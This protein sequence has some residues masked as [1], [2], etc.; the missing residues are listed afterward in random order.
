MKFLCDR[1]KTRYSIGDDRVRGKILKIR[2]KNCA[3][4]ITVREGMSDADAAAPAE[5]PNGRTQRPTTMSPPVA[6]SAPANGAKPPPALDEEWYVSIE[7]E[8]SGPFSLSQAQKWIG[9]KPFDADLHCWSEG[10]DDWLP[11][12][13]VSHFRGVR[14]PPAATAPAGA[15][16]PHP[17]NAPRPPVDDEP[18]PLFAATMASLER[19]SAEPSNRLGL[20]PAAVEAR[21]IVKAT[22]SG[23]VPVARTNG[24]AVPTAAKGTGSGNAAAPVPTKA[25]KASGPAPIAPKV[26]NATG[27]TMVGSAS[28]PA[29]AGNAT[30][31]AKV[32]SASGPVPRGSNSRL[33]TQPGHVP[34]A[35]AVPGFDLPASEPQD[36]ATAAGNPPYPDGAA[37]TS[38]PAFGGPVVGPFGAAPAPAP[39]FAPPPAVP[40]QAA[41]PM[42]PSS[43]PAPSHLGSPAPSAAQLPNSS[44]DDGL[45]IGEVS[46]VVNLADLM[47]AGPP[48]DRTGPAR[49]VAPANGAGLARTGS[50]PRMEPGTSPV[51]R[52]TGSMPVGALGGAHEAALL[53]ADALADGLLPG[54]QPPPPPL[55]HRRSLV[56]LLVVAVFLLGGVGAVVAFALSGNDDNSQ[57]GL[58]PTD[59][60]QIDTTRPEDL[61]RHNP[62]VPTP[63]S[64]GGTVT[65]PHPS[66]SGS[67]PRPNPNNPLGPT[68]GSNGKV[69][70]DP[71]GP[72]MPLKPDEVEDMS[73]KQGTGTSRC[74]ERA[75]RKQ[76]YLQKD[77][78]KVSVTITVDALGAV[79]NVQ[80]AGMPTDDGGLGTCLQSFIRG[81]RFRQSSAGI[82]AKFSMVFQNG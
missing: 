20:P 18:K 52:V 81:W 4:V 74:W 22:P 25:G 51:S 79:N 62:F 29:K 30:G 28:G 7:G 68:P 48:K 76:P 78:K 33:Q 66:G 24:A 75:L 49:R 15:P 26:G 56:A 39:L 44:D 41:P 32:G 61:I 23:G 46:R 50:V 45:D 67:H 16:P 3:N 80:I 6:H 21:P 71:L 77:I 8:Q 53:T 13:K 60:N 34:A 40:F 63:G 5:G 65:I 27:P 17:R 57:L 35:A 2:C 1:C 42:F 10:F 11:V 55:Q 43:A 47:R 14:K 73:S 36:R 12:D 37:P 72:T 58:G 64:N 38:L 70:G 59:Q 69:E 54:M 82:T 19:G 31:P 9:S